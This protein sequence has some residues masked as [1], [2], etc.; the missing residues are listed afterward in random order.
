M[1]S[2]MRFGVIVADH[3]VEIHEHERFSIKPD[4]VLIRNKACNLCTT[5]YQQWMGLRPHNPVPMAFGHESAGIVVDIGDEVENVKVGDHVTVNTYQPCLECDYC[6]KGYSSVYCRNS[7]DTIRIKN[8]YGYYGYYGCGDYQFAKAKYIFPMNKSLKF[9][10]AAFCEPLATVIHGIKKLNIKAG[11]K[12]LVIGVGT[13]GF[14]NAL[15][16]QYFGGDV[17][18]SEVS[19][20]KLAMARDFGFEKTINPSNE[21]YIEKIKDYTKGQDLN[22]IIIAV[23]STKA[24]NQALE[25]ASLGSKFLIFA[26]GYPAPTWSLEPNPVHYK[27]FQII[28]TY[29]C[30]TGD[31]QVASELLSDFSIDPTPLIENSY[32]L[33]D[34]E[35]AFE[36]AALPDTYRVS[37]NI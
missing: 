11:D 12:V 13:M 8:K 25:M 37:V 26:A 18:I 28:G 23:G 9:E 27:L 1:A 2:P 21:D 29:G 6:R 16:A 34:L 20:K 32:P 31:F 15:T 10:L 35:K 22:S 5:D 19:E 36:N 7:G 14:L 3:K 4:E 24:Y 17:I 30:S 33:N